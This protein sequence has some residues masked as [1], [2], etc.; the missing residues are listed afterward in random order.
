MFTES[1]LNEL[2]LISAVAVL[3]A[4]IARVVTTNLATGLRSELERLELIK[5]RAGLLLTNVLQQK[6]ALQGVQAFYQRRKT[7]IMEERGLAR[8]AIE[9]Y[10]GKE[11]VLAGL[12]ER[13]QE[14]LAELEFTARAAR[15]AT[16]EETISISEERRVLATKRLEKLEL[17]LEAALNEPVIE[18]G[19]E[20]EESD[21]GSGQTVDL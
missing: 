2:I 13:R 17:E 11:E 3:G 14:I 8:D 4:V 6:G 16:D 21:A 20:P 1:V 19:S 10:E 15:D 7:E 5:R 18:P 9:L 12:E